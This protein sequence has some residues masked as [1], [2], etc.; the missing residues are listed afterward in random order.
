[1]RAIGIT[2]RDT[3]PA[4]LDLPAPEPRAGEVRVAVEAA[5]VNGFDAAVAAGYVWDVLPY[6]FPVVLGRDVAGTVDAVGDGVTGIAVGDRVTGA[7]RDVPRP[8]RDDGRAGR[9]RR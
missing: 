5:T 4:E 1:M 2:A 6:E 9:A 8:G 3:G 7:L